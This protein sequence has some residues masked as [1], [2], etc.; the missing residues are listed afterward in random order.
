[1]F[2]R[3]WT[4]HWCLKRGLILHCTSCDLQKLLGMQPKLCFT[5]SD[6]YV[7]FK[8]HLNEKKSFK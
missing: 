8:L 2:L 5:S 1:M 3:K 4:Q 6:V 7:S